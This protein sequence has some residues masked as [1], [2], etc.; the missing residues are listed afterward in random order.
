MI[1]NLFN[2]ARRCSPSIIFIDDVQE[3]ASQ[4]ENCEF[5]PNLIKVN[6][7]IRNTALEVKQVICLL[8][9]M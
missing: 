4:Q 2:E 8:M 5:D 6:K 9:I 7:I 1:N 3:I